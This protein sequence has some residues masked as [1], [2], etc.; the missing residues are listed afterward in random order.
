[1]TNEVRIAVRRCAEQEV[2]E[3][4]G[5]GWFFGGIRQDDIS[6]VRH[7]TYGKC[8]LN[9]SVRVLRA[10]VVSFLRKGDTSA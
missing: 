6:L 7:G 10:S 2:V 1:M 5:G 3:T 4:G 9:G 8:K